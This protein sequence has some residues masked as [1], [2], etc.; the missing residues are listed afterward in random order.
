MTLLEGTHHHVCHGQPHFL[1]RGRKDFTLTTHFV[2]PCTAPLLLR[3]TVRICNKLDQ[4]LGDWSL[5][6]ASTPLTNSGDKINNIS[7]VLRHEV[8]Q[9]RGHIGQATRTRTCWKLEELTQ[10]EVGL[11][12]SILGHLEEAYVLVPDGRLH[13]MGSNSDDLH[14]S[15]G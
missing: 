6:V 10:V 8:C 9:E 5:Q 14:C 4:E 13:A 3:P 7:K 1:P 12:L 15:T 11:W 2:H